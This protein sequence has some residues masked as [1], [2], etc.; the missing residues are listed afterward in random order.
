M[1]VDDGARD[2]RRAFFAGTGI[3]TP[4]PRPRRVNRGVSAYVFCVSQLES[5]GA[6]VAVRGR[7]AVTSASLPSRRSGPRGRTWSGRL[8]ALRVLSRPTPKLLFLLARGSGAD[9]VAGM[10]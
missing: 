10:A 7:G 4:L 2:T 9:D 1:L 6:R 8:V 3:T 5:C